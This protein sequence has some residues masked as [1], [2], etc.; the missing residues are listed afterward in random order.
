M[1][2][3]VY[4]LVGGCHAHIVNALASWCSTCLASRGGG[5]DVPTDERSA[6]AHLLMA[7]PV[8]ETLQLAYPDVYVLT[9]PS[10]DWGSSTNGK[11]STV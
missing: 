9:D 6:A 7:A 1:P 4:V 11:V 8:E 5:R 3:C 10:G 2:L